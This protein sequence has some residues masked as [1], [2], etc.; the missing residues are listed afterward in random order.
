MENC[1]ELEGKIVIFR[2]KLSEL[3]HKRELEKLKN[4]LANIDDKGIA[5]KKTMK[6]VKK[7]E[8]NDIL[9]SYDEHF[10]IKHEYAGQM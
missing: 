3:I 6:L 4:I 5:M 8:N 9:N 10:G 2:S 7:I 1:K